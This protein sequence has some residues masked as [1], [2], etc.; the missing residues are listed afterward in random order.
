[1]RYWLRKYNRYTTVLES[2]HYCNESQ[3]CKILFNN[4][5]TLSPIKEEDGVWYG[6]FSPGSDGGSAYKYTEISKEE[7]MIYSM[8]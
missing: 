3:K 6:W 8:S 1:M 5:T 7:A 4:N 2:S